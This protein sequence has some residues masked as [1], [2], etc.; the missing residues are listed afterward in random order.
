[1]EEKT[2]LKEILSALKNHSENMNKRF[3]Q[4]DSRM[5]KLEERV[6]RLEEK[7]DTGFTEVNNRLNRLEKK[8]DR[9]RDDLKETQETVDFLTSKNIQHEKKL[10]SLTEQNS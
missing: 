1:M 8:V 9:L 7:V 4:L 5:D 2:L 3:D 10:R 6:D